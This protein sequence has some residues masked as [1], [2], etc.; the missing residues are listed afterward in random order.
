MFDDRKTLRAAK[1]RA[2][3][4]PCFRAERIAACSG[5][6]RPPSTVIGQGW[7]VPRQQRCHAVRLLPHTKKK[8]AQRCYR[9]SRS[10]SEHTFSTVS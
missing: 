2:A 9:R 10:V 4:R 5:P 7:S 1:E 6:K 8:H 3:R